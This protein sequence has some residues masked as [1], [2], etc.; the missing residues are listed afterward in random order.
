MG[1]S[2]GKPAQ[3]PPKPALSAV[4]EFKGVAQFSATDVELYK[5]QVADALASANRAA[6]E[7]AKILAETTGAIPWKIAKW[8][9][10]TILI[11]AVIGFVLLIHDWIVGPTGDRWILSKTSGTTV[12]QGLY[13]S[14]A[15]YGSGSTTTDVSTYLS[16]QIVGGTSL[17][18]FVVGPSTVGLSADPVPGIKNTLYV[19]WYVGNGNYQQTTVNEGDQFPSLPTAG[20]ASG[21]GMQSPSPSIFS[22]IFG[23]GSGSSG[24]L[25]GGSHDAS[26]TTSIKGTNAPLSAQ[27][28]GAYSMQWWMFVKDW[29]YGFG[30]KKGVITRPDATNAGVMN[31]QI[32]LHPTDNTLQVSISLFPSSEGGAGKSTPAPAGHASS[33]DDVFL[34]EVPNI[35]LQTWFSASVSVFGRNVDIYIDGKLVKSCFLPGVPKPAVGDIQVTPDG[36][37]SGQMCGFYHYPRMLTPADALNFWSS[38]SSC[39]S[40]GGA[41]PASKATGYSV[42]FG[43][44]DSVGKEVQEYSF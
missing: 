18:G 25:L 14:S 7:Q 21:G 41:T 8:V 6:T 39:Q 13:I 36:G 15:K 11:G 22:S 31:P 4:P 19:T 20:A 33:T 29:N 44:Y 28:D 30:K 34:C 35:P 3:G 37:F 1:G 24:D 23:S 40:S 43:V 27:G 12:V 42:K 16:N 17:P 9:G 32:S 5:R 2:I 38:G 10:I 26:T